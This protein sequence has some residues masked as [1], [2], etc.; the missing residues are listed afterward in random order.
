MF[1]R[2]LVVVA[3]LNVAL[4]KLLAIPMLSMTAAGLLVSA[5]LYFRREGGKAGEGGEVQFHN[6]FE[7]T[8][9]LKFAAFYAAV[10]LAS[11]AG[12]TY[13]GTG[14]AYVTGALA[15]MGDV[16]AISLSMANLAKEALPEKVAVTTILIASASNTLVK[17]G[18]AI[19]LGGWAFGRI[20][21]AAFGVVLLSGAIALAGIWML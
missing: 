18:L 20:V 8:S 21:G 10:L 9:A 14:A 5:F 2:V 12:V 11:K 17:G 3:F 4:A 1:A 15:G 13:L 6:P 7:L 19:G 16:D